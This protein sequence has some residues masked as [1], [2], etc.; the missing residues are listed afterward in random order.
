MDDL[1]RVGQLIERERKARH[2]TQDQL[3]ALVGVSPNTI[4]RL[5]GGANTTLGTFFRTL[6][7]LKAQETPSVVDASR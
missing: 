6:Q 3:A 4:Y 1:V 5:E 7:V 2:M